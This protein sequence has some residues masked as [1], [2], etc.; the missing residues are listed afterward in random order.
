[1]NIEEID[2]TKVR[3]F[4]ISE[5][6]LQGAISV[7]PYTITGTGT[8]TIRHGEK[9]FRRKAL[10][11]GTKVP[12]I[13][14]YQ[15]KRLGA[16]A[17]FGLDEADARKSLEKGPFT[18]LYVEIPIADLKKYINEDEKLLRHLLGLEKAALIGYSMSEIEE[19]L[20]GED[21]DEVSKMYGTFG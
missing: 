17:V 11:P 1:M 16:I 2:L 12:L 21:E 6:N 18:D 9:D 5:V 15:G 20:V 8:Y 4:D 14:V 7:G 3:V 19:L 13:D 10:L